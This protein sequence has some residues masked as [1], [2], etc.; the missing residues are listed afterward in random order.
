MTYTFE[1]ADN[2]GFSPLTAHRF[3]CLKAQRQTTWRH[4]GFLAAGGPDHWRAVAAAT[5]RRPDQPVEDAQTLTA[6]SPSQ[7]ASRSRSSRASSLWPGAQPTGT[8]GHARLGPGW[9]IAIRTSFDGVTFQSPPIDA[10]RA[11]D[12]LDRGSIRTRHSAGCASTATARLP[13]TIRPSRRSGFADQYM[14]LVRRYLELVL[15][16]GA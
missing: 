14:A 5:G 1:I 3:C 10:L 7:A 13:S 9:G 12:L 11:F 4:L 8:A 15:R 16:V 6:V 2:S